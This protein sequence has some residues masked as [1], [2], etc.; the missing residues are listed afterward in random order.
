MNATDLR[1]LYA[2]HRWAN[3]RTLDTAAGLSAEEVTRDL[4]SSFPSVLATLVHLLSAEWIWLE[5]WKGNSPAGWP[6]GESLVTFALLRQKWS[7][8]EREQAAL[9]ESRGDEGF[10][11]VIAYRNIKGEPYENPLGDILQHVVNHGTY[12]RGQLATMFR[13]LGHKPPAT[14]F[15]QYLRER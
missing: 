2:F 4:R 6:A 12:H 1:R 15:I 14:D 3:A 11:R 13:Q 9:L 10:A 8:V 5:R 7:E